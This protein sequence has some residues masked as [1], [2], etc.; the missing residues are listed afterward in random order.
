M[1]IRKIAMKEIWS[2]AENVLRWLSDHMEK[3]F[4]PRSGTDVH[5]DLIVGTAVR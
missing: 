3:E 2:H 4:R 5:M 1:L